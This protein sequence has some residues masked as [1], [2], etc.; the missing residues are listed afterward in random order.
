MPLQIS[1]AMMR[2]DFLRGSM[3]R[4]RSISLWTTQ[5]EFPRT[6]IRWMTLGLLWG[7]TRPVLRLSAKDFELLL[8][9]AQ[10]SGNIEEE[11]VQKVRDICDRVF[12]KY[13]TRK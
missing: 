13:R 9:D 8:K 10:V 5:T 2:R 1:T 3:L 12:A 11:S 6:V 7:F 4:R